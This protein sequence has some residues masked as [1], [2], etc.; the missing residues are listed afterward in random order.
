MN[1]FC[2]RPILFLTG[3]L[4]ALSGMMFS[5]RVTPTSQLAEQAHD[6]Q[7]IK[8]SGELRDRKSVV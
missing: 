7:Q 2:I 3:I 4:M 1:R 8:D 5:C 6:L